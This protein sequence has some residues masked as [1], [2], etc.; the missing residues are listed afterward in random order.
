MSYAANILHAQEC[1]TCLDDSVAI[2]AVATGND[3]TNS[4]P[5]TEMTKMINRLGFGSDCGRCK[6]LANEMDQ[7][8]PR[9]VRANREYVVQRTISNAKNLGQPMGPIQQVGARMLVQKAIVKSEAKQFFSKI[10]RR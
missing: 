7:G 8:G 3:Q 10:F 6:A 2:A 9:W 1:E 5:G 4:G